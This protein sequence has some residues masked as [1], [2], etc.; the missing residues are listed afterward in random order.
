MRKIQ[1][2]FLNA[3]ALAALAPSAVLANNTKEAQ[4]AH[5]VQSSNPGLVVSYACSGASSSY[6]S[7]PGKAGYLLKNANHT[8]GC[9]NPISGGSAGVT[10]FGEQIV[11]T[12]FT[13]LSFSLR[14]GKNGT[15]TVYLITEVS[16]F[17][18]YSVSFTNLQGADFTVKPSQFN[19]PVAPGTPVIGMVIDANP[20]Q[21]V[22]IKNVSLNQVP[23][24]LQVHSGGSCPTSIICQPPN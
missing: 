3:L 9:G 19:P 24:I 8:Y 10:Y 20:C 6:I 18:T 7:G 5:S 22:T 21:Q 12:P 15:V 1:K 11:F 17:P 23:G 13:N 4:P 16:P 2:R 14:N